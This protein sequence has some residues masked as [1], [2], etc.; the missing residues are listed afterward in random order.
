MQFFVSRQIFLQLGPLTVTYYALTMVTGAILTYF[1]SK[2]AIIKNGYNGDVIDDLFIGCFLFGVI[3]ARIW[4]CLF[5]NLPYYLANP[6]HILYIFEGGL[7]IQGG[8]FAGALF[9][10]YYSKKKRID[11]MRMADAI[12]PNI[13]LAQAIGRWGNFINQ[14][15]HGSAVSEQFFHNFPQF[16]K[17]G[18]LI[19]G[20]YYEPTFLYES[21]LNLLGFIVFVF[22]IKKINERFS[23]LKRGDGVW[24][25]LVW[26]G[27]S[28]YFIEGL[29]TDSL[30]FLGLRMAQ[31]ISIV[32]IIIGVIGLAGG[33]RFLIKRKKPIILFDLDGTLLDTAPAIIATY[34]SLFTK[35][36]QKEDFTAE[37]QLEVLGP[38][39]NEMFKK[40]FPDQDEEALIQEYRQENLRLHHSVVSLMKNAKE[41]LAQLVADGYTLGVVSTK[42]QEAIQYGLKLFAIDEY[43]RVI[44]G[45]DDVSLQKPSPEGILLACNKLKVNHDNLIYVGDSKTDIQA[46]KNAG[47]YTIGYLFD[48][49]RSSSL[50]L[51]KPNK[52]ISDLSDILE[53]VKED[54]E[55]TVNMM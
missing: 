33:Y 47:A 3:G 20:V 7:A 9:G 6:L 1:F 24:F 23:L 13:L 5:Y 17:D 15:A 38:S 16:I 48:P 34:Q 25:Y 14:E 29:R 28:R 51:A 43:F 19:N 40:Y 8:L 32:F 10:L 39:L 35:Y 44:I 41:T 22:I 42:H 54:H 21:V 27:I 18:M 36:R 45:G 11:F 31:V 52:I 50:T 12:V 37:I 46:G 4:F 49:Q 53:I 55:W 30:M 26:Y 2:K